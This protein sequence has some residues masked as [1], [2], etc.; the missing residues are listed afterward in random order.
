[1]GKN[2]QYDYLLKSAVV[3]PHSS[4]KSSLILRL[5]DDTFTRHC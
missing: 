2:V 1:M 3:G 4:G 5:T